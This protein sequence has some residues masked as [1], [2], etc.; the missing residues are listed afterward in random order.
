[1]KLSSAAVVLG[2]LPLALSKSIL[3]TYPKDTPD[4]VIESAKQDVKNAGGT[5]THEYS[6]VVKGFSASD[7]SEEAIQ[8][9]S[10]Q[11]TTYKPTVEEDQ[12]VSIS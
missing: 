10:T 9:I 7:A 12:T 6:L 2:L 5:I 4:S 11:S 8:Q 1:M 3:V